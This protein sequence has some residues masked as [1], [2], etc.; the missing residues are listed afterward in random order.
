MPRDGRD[1]MD[2]IPLKP[3]F[4]LLSRGL[5]DP[6]GATRRM[7]E[8]APDMADRF[9]MVGL[10]AVLQA[11]LMSLVA[12]TAPDFVGAPDRGGLG[13]GAHAALVLAVL[14]GYVVTA[15]LAYNIGARFGG[16]GKP[17][18]VATAVALHALLA[19]ALTPLQ[20]AAMGSG[21]GLVLV[22]YLGLNIWL[23]AS[24]VAEAHGFEKT[25]PVAGA[26]VGIFFVV[27]MIMSF[28]VLAFSGA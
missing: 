10:A 18:D 22:L 27:A 19:A 11:L 28:F 1:P 5:V 15:T 6:R 23:L 26:T 24:C 2:A 8:V 12:V 7:L 17:A 25:A 9:I 20:I 14:L 16:A 13:F 4:D 3:F 21:A